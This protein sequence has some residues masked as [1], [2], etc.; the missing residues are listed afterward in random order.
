MSFSLLDLGNGCASATLNAI[1]RV[2]LPP[3]F[4]WLEKE[5]KVR[6]VFHATLQIFLL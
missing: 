6:E 2:L 4:D 5:R 3:C 1:E